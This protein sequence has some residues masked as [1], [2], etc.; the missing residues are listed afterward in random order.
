MKSTTRSRDANRQWF[1]SRQGLQVP[2]TP[3]D[4]SFRG[5]V[6]AE[7]KALVV[8]DALKDTRFSDNP[9]VTGEPFV[10]FYAG[11]PLRTDDG[12]VLGTICAIDH[13]QRSLTGKQ[14]AVLKRLA[15]QAMNQLDMRRRLFLLTDYERL[16]ENSNAMPAIVS[17]DGYFERVNGTWSRMLGYSEAELLSRPIFE[18]VHEDDVE[19][20]RNEASRLHEKSMETATY[21]SRFLCADGS[22]KRL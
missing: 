9:F 18:F 16:F 14:R 1:K 3:R 5:H 2:E 15:S 7:E 6:V 19:A 4:V 8:E 20:T 17:L 11:C 21:S 12:H 10:R 13:E 22:Y